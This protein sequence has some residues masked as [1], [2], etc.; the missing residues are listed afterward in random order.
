MQTKRSALFLSG[1]WRRPIAL[2]LLALSVLLAGC[3][4]GLPANVDRQ[5]SKAKGAAMDTPLGRIAK[6]STLDPE[7]SGFRLMPTGQ[8]ALQ[9]RL[10]QAAPRGGR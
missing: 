3:A 2:G 4:T 10:A 6:A 8:F 5:P 7:Q 1:R 9:A